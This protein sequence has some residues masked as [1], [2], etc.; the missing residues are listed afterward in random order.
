MSADA[1]WTIAELLAPSL[2][3][4]M[5]FRE[6]ARVVLALRRAGGPRRAVARDRRHV[7]HEPR[8]RRRRDEVRG[9]RG[10]APRLVA[11]GP[12]AP[13][14]D[15]GAVELGRGA[16]ARVAARLRSRLPARDVVGVRAGADRSR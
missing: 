3:R 1:A 4:R 7:A 10:P 6:E 12:R 13:R 9:P 15:R 14:M 2:A 8:A 5:G 16:V 11:A